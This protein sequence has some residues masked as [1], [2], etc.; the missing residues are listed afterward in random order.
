MKGADVNILGS[1]CMSQ[2]LGKGEYRGLLATVVLISDYSYA[3]QV[4]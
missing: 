1:I 2:G 3:W 4:L